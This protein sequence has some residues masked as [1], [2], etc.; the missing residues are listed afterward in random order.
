[1]K[2]ADDIKTITLARS[3]G[4]ISF[5]IASYTILS[6]Q[7]VEY[8]SYSIYLMGIVWGSVFGKNALNAK[9]GGAH[10]DSVHHSNQRRRVK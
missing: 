3:M 5:C 8:V 1:M 4:V 9:T 2:F 10:A 6:R 7:P